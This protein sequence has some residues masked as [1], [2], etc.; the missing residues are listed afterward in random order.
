MVITRT[1]ALNPAA[2]AALLFIGPTVTLHTF[3]FACEDYRERL[4][5]LSRLQRDDR[6]GVSYVAGEA[7]RDALTEGSLPPT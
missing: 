7:Y 2:A 6:R 3:L 5:S 1:F 4:K